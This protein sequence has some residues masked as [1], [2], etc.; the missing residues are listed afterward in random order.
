M[1]VKR[2]LDIFFL[3]LLYFAVF[4]FLFSS[5]NSLEKSMILLADSRLVT[6]RV[7]H[8]LTVFFLY[9]YQRFFF[10]S[11]DATSSI[12]MHFQNIFIDP[13]VSARKK[14]EKRDRH[15]EREKER[16]RRFG[17]NAWSVVAQL[18]DLDAH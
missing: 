14:A 8:L 10:A 17:V 2:Q 13:I 1:P 9:S 11:R 18:K 3:L 15:E 5:S 7:T 16:K 6:F 4:R 12:W